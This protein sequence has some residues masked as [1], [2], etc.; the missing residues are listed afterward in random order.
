[1]K[2][3][4]LTRTLVTMV[5]SIL[6]P[7]LI[8]RWDKRRMSPLM[9][10]RCWTIATWGSALYAFGPLSLLGW[11]WVTRPRWR[12]VWMGP[13]WTCGAAV[14]L[15]LLDALVE[16]AFTGSTEMTLSDLLLGVLGLLVGAVALLTIM[17]LVTALMLAITRSF[18]HRRAPAGEVPSNPHKPPVETT[19]G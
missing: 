2:G 18:S 5:V 12:R 7:W 13:L 14:G 1:M 16:V 8:Q 11:F 4:A 19:E 6:V 10:A 17:E 3:L 9:R 15:M